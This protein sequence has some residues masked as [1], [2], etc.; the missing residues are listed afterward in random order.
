MKSPRAYAASVMLPDGRWWILGGV[1]ATGIHKTTDMVSYNKTS[2]TFTVT[3]GK[4][5][6]E[7]R[8]GHCA[9][10]TPDGQYVLVVGGHGE[11]NYAV[12]GSLYN[13]KTGAWVN[14]EFLNYDSVIDAAC[15]TVNIQDSY[16]KIF[17]CQDSSLRYSLSHFFVY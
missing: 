2:K 15:G 9:A 14:K 11:N 4:A 7:A 8:F 1:G 6:P 17:L 16:D 5:M 13:L 12:N 3:S 10:L